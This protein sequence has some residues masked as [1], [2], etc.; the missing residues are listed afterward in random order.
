MSALSRPLNTE[1]YKKLQRFHNSRAADSLMLSSEEY[2]AL[3]QFYGLPSNTSVKA[4]VD[5]LACRSFHIAMHQFK[6]KMVQATVLICHGYF[7]HAGLYGHLIDFLVKKNVQVFCFDMPGHGLSSGAK[8]EI[9]QFSDYQAILKRALCH[10]ETCGVNVSALYGI[11][12]S[13]GGAIL[14]DGLSSQLNTINLKGVALL[15]PLV[16]P[17]AWQQARIMQ[18]ILAGKLAYWPRKFSR[19]SSDEKFL[20]FLKSTDPL[21]S[22]YLSV[23]WVGAL[24]KWIPDIESRP[25]RS[26]RVLVIQGAEDDTVDWQHNLPVIQGLFGTVKTCLIAEAGHQLVNEADALRT[27]VFQMLA[28]ELGL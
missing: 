18:S 21:Q 2:H 27:Q 17:K 13:T 12:Q 4:S 8:V 7:D 19:N 5:Y 24:N 11:G 15:A 10:I 1:L 14:I 26:Q 9:K 16:R 6:P 23:N 22:R 20:E 28:Q 3:C 25:M